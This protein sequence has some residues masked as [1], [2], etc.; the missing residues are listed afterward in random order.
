MRALLAKITALA[1][2]CALTTAWLAL[3]P[4]PYDHTLSILLNKR[5]LLA[6]TPSPKLVLAGGSGLLAGVDS[7]LVA[8]ELGVNT[9]NLGVYAGCGLDMLPEYIAPY[10]HQGDVVV[11]VPEYAQFMHALGLSDVECRRWMLRSL[12]PRVSQK[13]YGHPR[14]LL[15][16]ITSLAA[17]KVRGILL[18]TLLSDA[19]AFGSGYVKYYAN[20]DKFGDKLSG[21]P[22]Q[23]KLG[24]QDALNFNAKT[25]ENAKE[26]LRVLSQ[27]LERRNV[28]LRVVPQAAAESWFMRERPAI[29]ALFG[30]LEPKDVVGRPADFAFD[31]SL[32][33][34][35]VNHLGP[36]GRLLRTE[37]LIQALRDDGT[38]LM[39]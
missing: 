21:F 2:V 18:A 12:F 7:G 8:K 4:G 9:V 13:L 31:D 35:T 27:S 3:G 23:P 22:S 1:L 11:I 38:F 17:S 39:P 19:S 5:D 29:D 30:T 16:D 10:I 25:I 6:R 15:V 32:F 26:A 20:F 24:G 33:Q 34:D 28:R 37:R 36:T 14:E